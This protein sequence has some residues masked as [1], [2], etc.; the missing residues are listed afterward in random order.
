MENTLKRRKKMTTHSDNF[1]RAEKQYE[2]D[3]ESSELHSLYGE[4]RESGDMEGSNETSED[5]LGKVLDPED[6]REESE[7]S[8]PS[9][10]VGSPVA[11][12][13]RNFVSL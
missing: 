9:P 6:Q 4:E 7:E 1:L 3:L 12:Y 10:M 8:S 5:S 13:W 2:R 11:W